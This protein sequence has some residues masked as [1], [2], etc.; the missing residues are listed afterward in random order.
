M[1]LHHIPTTVLNTHELRA[2]MI[3]QFHGMRLSIDGDMI[4]STGHAESG[5]GGTCFYYPAR[6]LNRKDVADESVPYAWTAP[7]QEWGQP[8]RTPE[9]SEHTWSVQGNAFAHWAVE[10]D[11]LPR[12]YS[13]D[14][15]VMDRHGFQMTGPMATGDA[16]VI[17][18]NA[19]AADSMMRCTGSTECSH[20][21]RG[22]RVTVNRESFLITELV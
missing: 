11:S 15:L 14:D 16:E 20:E 7:R 22:W 8:Y 4:K 12:F 17:V 10:T 5:P 3:V 18:R 9:L 6:V 1:S 2:G 13:H 21:D 19:N